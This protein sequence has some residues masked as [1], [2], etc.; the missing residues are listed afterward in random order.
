MML[1][2]SVPVDFLRLNVC[3]STWCLYV[4]LTDRWTFGYRAPIKNIVLPL[5]WVAFGRVMD[6]PYIYK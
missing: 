6:L 2:R 5:I 3:H 4:G 1:M